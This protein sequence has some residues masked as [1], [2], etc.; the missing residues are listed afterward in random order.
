M[1]KAES[2]K[3]EAPQI[4]KKVLHLA[5]K[6]RDTWEREDGIVLINLLSQSAGLSMR[7][8]GG[9]IEEVKLLRNTAKY[10][11]DSSN[12]SDKDLGNHILDVIETAAK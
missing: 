5:D 1:A 2:K 6:L 12:N 11:T 3:K 10:L 8:E 4:E 9:E 7:D